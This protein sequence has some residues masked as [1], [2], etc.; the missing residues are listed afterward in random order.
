MSEESPPEADE[1]QLGAAGLVA[2]SAAAPSS[3]GLREARRKTKQLMRE[4]AELEHVAR[5]C[6]GHVPVRD[7]AGEYLRDAAGTVQT[8]P[9]KKAPIRGG[10][11][12]PTHGGSAPQVKKK[13]EKRLNAMLEPAII[14]MDYLMHQNDHLPTALAASLAVQNRVLGAV[15]KEGEA[16]DTRPIINIGI[17]AGGVPTVTV[18]TNMLP[19]GRTGDVVVDGAVED[20]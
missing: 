15:G 2:T 6:R 1:I 9:C 13:A 7:A 11:V 3:R 16:K 17:Q 18:T 8:R 14:R 20:E 4:V 10:S 19:D 12:C 5:K